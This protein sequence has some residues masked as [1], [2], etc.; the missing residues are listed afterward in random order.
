MIGIKNASKTT[1][2]IPE[3]GFD[4]T[5]LMFILCET[6]KMCILLI[7]IIYNANN[8]CAAS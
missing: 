5:T 4:T 1:R 2:N 3:T 7:I 8:V 6:I